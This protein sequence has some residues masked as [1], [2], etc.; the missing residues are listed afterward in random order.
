LF[1]GGGLIYPSKNTI[2]SD[3]FF[4]RGETKTKHRHFSMSEGTYKAILE[5][6]YYKKR[7][8]NPV[9]IGGSATIETPLNTNEYGYKASNL[10]DVSLTAL[11]KEISQIGAALSSGFT[12]RHS[13]EAFWNGI[14]TPNSRSTILT[15]G[16]GFIWSLNT[17]GISL[18]LQKPFFLNGR[19]SGI[20]GE[21][22]QEVFA[23][24]ISL[25]Y[26]HVLDYIIPWLDPLK[27]L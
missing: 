23:Y 27:E 26:R 13:T 6:Q 22:D 7:L 12:I 25:S 24:Q 20:E 21:I 8:S 15:L 10:Y 16:L 14:P 1:V 3:P 11:T 18:N 17:G 19:F 4:L 5:S 9:F 2:T